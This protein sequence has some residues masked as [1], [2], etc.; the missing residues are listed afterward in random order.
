MKSDILWK[1]LFFVGI[2]IWIGA[3]MHLTYRLDYGGK[4]ESRKEITPLFTEKVIKIEKAGNSYNLYTPK[5]KVYIKIVPPEPYVS[6]GDTTIFV[7]NIKGKM[8]WSDLLK[9]YYYKSDRSKVIH[10]I[11]ENL[12]TNPIVE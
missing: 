7:I 9:S 3:L 11:F 5:F 10:Y 12:K 6:T 2:I 4:D 8:I 1:S